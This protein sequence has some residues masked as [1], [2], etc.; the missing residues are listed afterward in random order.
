MEDESFALI[1]SLTFWQV[2]ARQMG[3]R[4]IFT[5]TKQRPMKELDLVAYYSSSNMHTTEFNQA[6]CA[7]YPEIH[8]SISQH[9]DPSQA[10][11]QN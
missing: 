8:D 4:E 10:S 1:T 6:F 7:T 11:A 5:A 9:V 2:E 3:H